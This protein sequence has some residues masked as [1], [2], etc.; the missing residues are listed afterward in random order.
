M[1]L[2]SAALVALSTS[3][4]AYATL[5]VCAAWMGL[6]SLGRVI[7]RVRVQITDLVL[8]GI[9]V[10]AATA[11]LAVY[12]ADES[13]FAPVIRL[14]EITIFNKGTS[15]SAI[16]RGA[17][18][19]QALRGFL[20]TWGLGVGVGSTR[21]SSWAVAVVSHL[22][23]AGAALMTA[24]VGMMLRGQAGLDLTRAPLWIIGL[25]RG[26]RAAGLTILVAA[27]VSAPYADPGM[28][29][30]VSLAGVLACRYHLVA[31]GYARQKR[32]RGVAS[33]LRSR[34]AA[35]ESTG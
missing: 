15:D 27:T 28:L 29:F 13:L 25:A 10:V 21:A 34:P 17:W 9:G 24:L 26:C 4:T 14:L 23:I 2:P 22:G 3:T 18:N 5:A 33:L 6:A 32:R 12:L 8:L 31:S 16:E 19:A 35:A 7:L 30:F 1:L 20:D 11:L